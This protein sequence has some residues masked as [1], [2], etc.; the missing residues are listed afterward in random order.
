MNEELKSNL[1]SK[2]HW[3]RLVFMMLV[4]IFLYVAFFVTLVV[5]GMQFLFAL[6]T[7]NDNDNLRRLGGL[8]AAYINQCVS[9]LTYSSEVK[10]Y[11]FS[12]LPQ[13]DEV[14]PNTATEA[15]DVVELDSDGNDTVGDAFSSDENSDKY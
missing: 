5:I 10:P 15:T 1:L 3:L 13:V 2:K 11:P 9:F 12:D 7:G 8:L 4:F 6:I 14:Q